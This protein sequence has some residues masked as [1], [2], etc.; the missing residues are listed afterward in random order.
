MIQTDDV[1]VDVAELR[2]LWHDLRQ[3][4]AAAI[5]VA[6]LPAEDSVSEAL[7]QRLDTMKSLLHSMMDLLNAQSDF[8]T[9]GQG[10]LD[11]RRLVDESVAVV[12]LT[13][14]TAVTT[15][16]HGPVCGY[17]DRVMLRRALGNV[18]DNATRAAG[19]AGQIQV[20][21]AVQDDGYACIAVSDDGGGFGTIPSGT[22]QGLS[23]VHRALRE[24][25]GR[26]EIA[27]GPGPGTTV[28]MFIPSQRAGE[29]R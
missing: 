17:G 9:P 21:V 25:H 4:L 10:A 22:G 15:T 18:L 7:Q 8:D 20:S 16:G 13:H 12:R 26:M 23:V 29:H 11:L 24:C 6:E 5:L 1:G 19:G 2:Q 28:R 27:S 14:D 3:Q